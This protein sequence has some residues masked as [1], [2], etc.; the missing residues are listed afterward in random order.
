MISQKLYYDEMIDFYT[1]LIQSCVILQNGNKLFTGI[2]CMGIEI[3]GLR[4]T[5]QI[6]SDS[7]TLDF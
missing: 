4:N 2:F 5:I 6:I 7:S 3:K 1:N